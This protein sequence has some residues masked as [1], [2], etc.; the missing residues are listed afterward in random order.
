MGHFPPCRPWP[1]ST[2]F[3]ASPL[4]LPPSTQPTHPPIHSIHRSNEHDLAALVPE[5]LPNAPPALQALAACQ[6]SLGLGGES[7]SKKGGL[8]PRLLSVH[9]PPMH[10]KEEEEEEVERR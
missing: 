4:P 9:A 6:A 7:E 1:S 3:G 8:I 5:D 2:S 10:T